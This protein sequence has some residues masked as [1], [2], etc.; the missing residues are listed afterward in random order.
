MRVHV[1]LATAT[2]PSR[3]SKSPRNPLTGRRRGALPVS[4][5]PARTLEHRRHVPLRSR[6]RTV[7]GTRHLAGQQ[8][9]PPAHAA[10]LVG[11]WWQEE[12]PHDKEAA[13]SGRAGHEQS[14]PP[15]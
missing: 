10:Q 14:I 12:E 6:N 2:R 1:G 8:T 3:H 11:N 13:H 9:L 5:P 4:Q 7:L 15:P